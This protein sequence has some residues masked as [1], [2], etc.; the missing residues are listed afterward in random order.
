[1]R[2]SILLDQ[3]SEQSENG[4][5]PDPVYFYCTRNPAEPERARS[6]P[7]LRSLVRQTACL[8]S[9]TCL[10]ETIRRAYLERKADGFAAGPLTLE[11]CTILLRELTQ[12]R[13]LTVIVIDALD[14]CEPDARDEL[15][16]ALF[17]LVHCSSSLVKVLISSREDRSI[18]CQMSDCLNL[19]ISATKNRTDINRFIDEEVERLVKEKR[20]LFGKVS[21]ALKQHIKNVLRTDA[22]GMLV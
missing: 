13:S 4:R 18:T 12:Q 5:N 7:V 20:L 8:R 3:L 1:M 22:H 9:G 6:A 2:R 14:E 16:K 19:Q 15:L 21:G 17:S 10:L 11:E